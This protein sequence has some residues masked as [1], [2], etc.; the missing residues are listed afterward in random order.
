MATTIYYEDEHDKRDG[1]G[2]N[3][4]IKGSSVVARFAT[5]PEAL[6]YANKQ[7]LPVWVDGDPVDV[8]IHYDDDMGWQVTEGS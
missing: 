8:G 6:R 5:A 1:M 3:V 7:H 4:E 2:W